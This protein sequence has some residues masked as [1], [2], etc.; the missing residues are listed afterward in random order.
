MSDIGKTPLEGYEV[1]ICVTGG[2]AAYKV[3]PMVSHLVQAG[4]GITVAMT[5]AAQKFV[6][7]AT[8]QALSGRR[9]FT[10]MW[11]PESYDDPQHLRLTGSADLCIIAPATANIIAKIACGI[12][13]DLVST[14]VVGIGCPML[15]APAM[16]A[17][18]WEN[19]V[20]QDNV[21]R[22]QSLGHH[23]IG[24][25]EGWQACRTVGTGRMAE[26]DEIIQAASDL[27]LKNTPRRG[28]GQP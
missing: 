8:F 13:D 2:I 21:A 1:V 9:V 5:E 25:G 6:G 24:P 14:A 22:L 11:A 20:V 26:P 27:L 28:T 16:N 4:A 17:R 18:M 10:D 15:L 19:K 12:A 7:V 3:C 23:L